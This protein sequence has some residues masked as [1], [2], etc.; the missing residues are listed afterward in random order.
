MGKDKINVAAKEGKPQAKDCAAKK[1]VIAALA[2]LCFI[3]DGQESAAVEFAATSRTSD[4][5]GG[6]NDVIKARVNN[7]VHKSIKGVATG[8]AANSLYNVVAGTKDDYHY[9]TEKVNADGTITT[10]YWK[11]TLN[12]AK[13]GTAANI[14]WSEVTSAG[15]DTVKLNLPNGQTKYMRYTYTAPS[16]YTNVTTRTNTTAEEPVTNKVFR[17]NNTVTV[18]GGTSDYSGTSYGSASANASSTTYGGAVYNTSA[19]IKSDF[20]GSHI[21]QTISGGTAKAGSDYTYASDDYDES[22]TGSA[23]ANADAYASASA[24]ATAESNAYGGAVGGTSSMQ[25][26]KGN[27]VNNYVESNA[28][29]GYAKGGY[30][31]AH[32]GDA[33]AT[34]GNASD[35]NDDGS[36][37]A[38]ATASASAD[39]SC[40]TTADTS[41]V[42]KAGGGAIYASNSVGNITGDFTGNYVHADAK[43]GTSIHGTSMEY[44]GSATVTAGSASASASK[45]YTL[46]HTSTYY[47]KDANG[48]YVYNDDGSRKQITEKEEYEVNLSTSA[49]SSGNRDSHS[50]GGYYHYWKD[51]SSTYIYSI[52]ATADSSTS[53][54][55]ST[56][57]DY[58]EYANATSYAYGGAIMYEGT[59]KYMGNITGNFTG[60]Y[61]LATAQ[62][63]SYQGGHNDTKSNYAKTYAYGGALYNNRGGYY[64]SRI[65]DITGSFTGN[66]A[67]AGC[68]AQGGAIYNGV[69]GSSST[70]YEK[71]IGNI[72]GDFNSNYVTTRDGDGESSDSLAYGG[73]IFNGSKIGDIT[74]NF[75]G[76]YVDTKLGTG[77]GGAIYN[78]GNY[79]QIG[80][81]KGDF[82]GNYANSAKQVQGGAI[83]NNESAR[84]TSISG[85]FNDNYVTTSSEDTDTS[86]NAAQGG[87]IYNYQSYIDGITS[88]EFNNN[89]VFS[90]IGLAQGGAIYNVIYRSTGNIG[91]IGADFIGNYA[92]S[93]S[94]GAQGGAIF[95]DYYSR[96]SSSYGIGNITGNFTGNYV[97]G[98]SESSGGAI[99]N[100]NK[101]GTITG[102]FNLNHVESV[103]AA[104]K[105]GAIYNNNNSYSYISNI[106]GS[107]TNNYASGKETSY[108][109]A[110]S[111][112]Y[113]IG[114]ITGSFKDNYVKSTSG[115]A[116]GGGI[117][118]N[119]TISGLNDGTYSGNYASGSTGAFGG[120]IYNTN[121]ISNGIQNSTFTG[122][123]VTTSSGDAQGGAIYNSAASY[124]N[125]NIKNTSF[126]DNYAKS[127]TGTA[128][129]GAIYTVKDIVIT[130]DNAATEFSGNYVQSGSGAKEA[131]AIYMNGANVTLTAQ[132]NGS[133]KFDDNINAASSSSYLYLQGNST[134]NIF[135]NGQVKTARTILNGGNLTFGTDTFK[136]SS[137]DANGGVINL[138]DE[139]IN[140]YNI[141]Y[142]YSSS[143]GTNWKLDVDLANKKADTLTINS[144]SGYV[145]IDKVDVTG[146]LEEDGSLIVQVIKN[147]TNSSVQL[148]L[149][150]S[151]TYRQLLKE[152]ELR[153]KMKS[154]L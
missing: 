1:I 91:N 99:Y 38:Y 121:S 131:E 134:G 117:Y 92:I 48:N 34:A 151:L 39:A 19:N 20:V 133:I 71:K 24:G 73:A 55:S 43:G 18:S 80:A 144:G 112:E 114:T 116:Y 42:A 81:I 56:S 93:E 138:Q 58:S 77:L 111:N 35:S 16:G 27:F 122:N 141:N 142:L 78:K 72:I 9:K 13:A 52:S 47:E 22:S 65:G 6:V 147:A 115:I 107:F 154:K 103:N 139:K 32:A 76:N 109:G 60:N 84:I 67:K 59:D 136:T 110:I 49:S 132:N 4:N 14:A 21:T 28:R 70:G 106:T 40:S 12:V 153:K 15:A 79:A 130:A 104:A 98:S 149:N 148:R 89:H 137:L 108:G 61:A 126:K 57:D 87:A 29:G 101:I 135:L 123:Y 53:T 100:Q 63:G 75:T 25:D 113:N 88:S 74:G 83:Y 120:A 90:K 51:G 26:I 97:K 118:N 140:N 68:E 94:A 85:K 37:S 62:G 36:A 66:W 8:F 2:G 46:T 119:S 17:V 128:H 30:A 95:N 124:Y 105:G 44:S 102:N 143:Y 125:L 152:T 82:T 31:E 33:H 146:V 64:Y 45:S 50:D 69:Q 145:Y 10:Q 23:S 129:G 150:S 7:A 86:K 41:A 96:G 127:T 11:I 54:S 3:G 5:E